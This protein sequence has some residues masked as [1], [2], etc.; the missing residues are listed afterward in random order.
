MS[1]LPEHDEHPGDAADLRLAEVLSG[2]SSG[3]DLR[4]ELEGEETAEAKLAFVELDPTHFEALVA[5]VPAP[6][7]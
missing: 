1:E 3:A 2:S 6:R 4:R 5:A 7:P